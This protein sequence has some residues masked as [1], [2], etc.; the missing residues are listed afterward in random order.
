MSKAAKQ[1]QGDASGLLAVMRSP[2][3]AKM[4][5]FQ[6]QSETNKKIISACVTRIE[7]VYGLVAER[8][9]IETRAPSGI[10]ADPSVIEAI[11]SINFS[12]SQAKVFKGAATDFSNDL[13]K[14][15]AKILRDDSDT[16]RRVKKTQ[17]KLLNRMDKKVSVVLE[18]D[19]C[20]SLI[21]I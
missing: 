16:R 17:R 1:F 3:A 8:P 5:A 18:S 10:W 4:T 7:E 19:H 15:T 11:R 12:S 13:R 14:A 20:L 9:A 2:V 6:S 21:H